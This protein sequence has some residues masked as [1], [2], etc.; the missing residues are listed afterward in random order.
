MFLNLS[1]GFSL[2][3]VLTQTTSQADIFFASAVKYFNLGI[4]LEFL[5]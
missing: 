1:L 5:L 3:L 2:Y 4:F